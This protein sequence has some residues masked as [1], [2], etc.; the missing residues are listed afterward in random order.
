[1]AGYGSRQGL[2]DSRT[3]TVP[4]DSIVNWRNISITRFDPQA[5]NDGARRNVN[6][7]EE[8]ASRLLHSISESLDLDPDK[9]AQVAL[10]FITPN[11]NQVYPVQMEGRAAS[12]V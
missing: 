3:L 12:G 6:S 8:V 11:G 2:S 4:S 7:R 5:G 10:Q 1:M 9:L